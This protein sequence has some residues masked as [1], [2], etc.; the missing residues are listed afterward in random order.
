MTGTCNARAN[1]CNVASDGEIEPFSMRESIPEERP[2]EFG[3]LDEAEAR[4]LAEGA[5]AQ[6]DGGF[7]PIDS[8]CL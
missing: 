8:R 6:S 7:E 3:E 5:N 2:G 4:G 1:A